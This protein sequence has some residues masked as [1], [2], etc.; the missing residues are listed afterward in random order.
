[1]TVRFCCARCS[2]ACQFLLIFC[3]VFLIFSR[4][5]AQAAPFDAAEFWKEPD[6]SFDIKT[7]QTGS[8]PA[9]ASGTYSTGGPWRRGRGFENAANDSIQWRAFI[10]TSEIYQDQP[11]RVYALYARP[12]G[13]GPFPAV[14][15]LHGGIDRAQL[16]RVVAFARA[17]YACLALDWL[18]DNNI[19][20]RA[21]A[22]PSRTLY[23]NLDYSD[24]GRMFADMSDDGKASL[25]YRAII[26]ARRAI[27]WIG[28]QNEID[29]ARIG[30]EGH[31]WGGYLAQ[32]LAGIEPRLKAVVSSA[33]AGSWQRRYNET[34]RHPAAPGTLPPLVETSVSD[35]TVAD[36]YLNGERDTIVDGHRFGDLSPQE[37]AVWS[38]RYDPASFAAHI[39][40]PILIRLGASDFFGSIDGLSDY[41][42]KIPAPKT[43]QLLPSDNHT[44]GDVETRVQ[45]FNYWLKENH[46]APSF[47]PQLTDWTLTPN[48]DRSW[49]VSV[50]DSNAVAGQLAWTTTSGP[51]VARHW[52]QR[53]LEKKQTAEGATWT[54]SFTPSSGSGA[55]R[56]F[57]SLQDAQ[58]HIASTLPRV[59]E[60]KS[61]TRTFKSQSETANG[62][63]KIAKTAISPLENTSMWSKAP[64]FGPLALSPEMI[65]ERSALLNALWDESALYLRVQVADATPWQKVRDPASWWNSDSVHLRFWLTG[66]QEA[67][68]V[69]H[70]VTYNSGVSPGLAAF[71]DI[72]IRHADTDLRPIKAQVN[73]ENKGYILTLR[74]PWRWL[75]S[76]FLPRSGQNFRMAF[77]VN[78]GDL[79]TNEPILAANFGNAHAL[80]KPEV[81][82]SAMLQ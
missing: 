57:V 38:Q 79:L 37:M 56:V 23:G 29:A 12:A 48:P 73:I 11:M 19:K 68:S 78:D 69:V 70:L 72:N 51:S 63:I 74:L 46:P 43:L 4:Q 45:W 22:A 25:I 33:A 76:Q 1:M 27:T 61:A 50:P 42:D 18:P 55:L 53:P 71:H 34:P 62:P 75:D 2:F 58:G 21:S 52:A 3:C 9:S 49:T 41:Y 26:A 67:P 6:I 80:H 35:A 17:G 47:Y 39:Q 82:G 32:L 20:V 15:S 14:L 10:F 8:E 54:A 44:F 31:S 5:T 7:V 40:A 24:W 77:L 64:P 66:P 30:V 59:L 13:N 60:A 16:N 28:Q 36:V 65:G 81:W